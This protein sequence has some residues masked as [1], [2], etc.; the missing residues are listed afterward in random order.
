M[1][2]LLIVIALES[3]RK[4]LVGELGQ[5]YQVLEAAE[6]AQAIELFHTFTPKVVILDVEG[7]PDL[8]G[9]AEGFRCLQ[10]LLASQPGTKVVVLTGDG[11]WETA[12]RAL[13]F[14]AYD[15]YH[16]PHN[17][18]ELQIVVRRAF[19]LS[20]L[21]EERCRLKETLERRGLGMEGVVGQCAAM[22]RVFAAAQMVAA[23]DLPV[24]IQGETGTGKELVAKT[25]RVLSSRSE[26]PFVAVQCE[27][28]AKDRME[29][30]LFGA[31]P[32]EDG[33]PFRAIIGDLEHARG[34]ILFLNEP[35]EL[36][37]A[38]QD[39]LLQVLEEGCLT[40]LNG[41][42]Q[43]PADA[44]IICATSKNLLQSMRSGVVKEKLYYRLSVATLELPPLRDRGDDIMLLAHLFL[45]RFA[46]AYNSKVRG[47]SPEAVEALKVHP[48][49]GN[50]GE[51]EGKVQRGVILS[52]GPFLDPAALGLVE[53]PLKE[54]PVPRNLSLREARDQAERKVIKTAIG[55]SRGNL[56]KASEL[57]D[58]SRSTLYD[59]LKKHGM[60]NPAARQ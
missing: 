55:F 43:I 39:K 10:W 59:L 9:A 24:L 40:R 4:E 30:E 20:C 1:E 42:V 58:V 51:L 47:F 41:T 3:L 54:E 8:G 11:D 29:A 44:R 12:H 35:A 37:F 6:Y 52:E 28:I 27:A 14:G 26:G 15:F 18:L 21:E 49:P 25:I 32:S 17:T 23:A 38:V 22:Q 45:R 53:D 7:A 33:G 46:Q 34:G 19:E 5:E 60:F 31:E 56:A 48:W 36:P 13:R 16:K 50:V 57:L 2:N